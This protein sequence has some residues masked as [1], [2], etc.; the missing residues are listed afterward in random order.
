MTS[1]SGREGPD[2]GKTFAEPE[3]VPKVVEEIVEEFV[4]ATLSP[5]G[6]KRHNGSSTKPRALAAATCCRIYCGCF[7]A[8]AVRRRSWRRQ[9]I[10]IARSRLGRHS[11][12]RV[13]APTF[14]IPRCDDAIGRIG[15]CFY[16]W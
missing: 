16:N 12:L 5:L 3:G 11:D 13:E 2:D 15:P 14:A 4:E 9:A 8:S 1:D 6:T 10:S 7:E